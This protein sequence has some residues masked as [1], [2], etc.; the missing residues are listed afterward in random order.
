MNGPLAPH[1]APHDHDPRGPEFCIFCGDQLQ[2]V[3]EEAVRKGWVEPTG[4][5]RRAK[6]GTMR[7]VYRSLIYKQKS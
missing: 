5:L 2:E 7:P 4:E 3:I 6:D 1:P